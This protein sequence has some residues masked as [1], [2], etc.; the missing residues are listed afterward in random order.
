MNKYIFEVLKREELPVLCKQ[1]LLPV[2]SVIE[3]NFK[4]E[5]VNSGFRN[6]RFLF[7]LIWMFKHIN[8]KCFILSTKIMI[9]TI[10]RNVVRR[11]C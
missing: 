2:Q 3:P 4:I 11:D 1:R 6:H 10:Y 7:E 9:M 8:R 5:G